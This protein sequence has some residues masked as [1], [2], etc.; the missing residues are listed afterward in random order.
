MYYI[1]T[2]TVQDK[3]TRR[4]RGGPARHI[5]VVRDTDNQDFMIRVTWQKLQESLCVTHG[6]AVE[7]VV[8]MFSCGS[9]SMFITP[10][11]MIELSVLKLLRNPHFYVR[12]RS[13]AEFVP[14]YRNGGFWNFAEANGSCSVASL[15]LNHS[16]TTNKVR[17]TDGDY[18]DAYTW[19]ESI[20]F[21]ANSVSIC[22]GSEGKGIKYVQYDVESVQSI[23]RIREKYVALGMSQFLCKSFQIHWN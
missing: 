3:R 6:V 4:Q 21:T 10:V 20:D 17:D 7:D 23:H 14:P 5:I 9:T 18:Y 19:S 11:S 1:S 8:G 13:F 2:E 12:E 22:V 15:L 16:V